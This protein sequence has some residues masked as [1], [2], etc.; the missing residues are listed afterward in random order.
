MS[1]L[2]TPTACQLGLPVGGLDA[3]QHRL[4]DHELA[5]LQVAC[6]GYVKYAE[7]RISTDGRVHLTVQLLQPH[8]GA[9]I[10]TIFHGEPGRVGEFEALRDRLLVPRTCAMLRG[11]R[12]DPHQKWRGND[13]VLLVRCSGVHTLGFMPER[14]GAELPRQEKE[15]ANA[16]R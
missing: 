13:V 10:V 7:V 8:D 5:E 1:A 2:A 12:L 14:R 11:E 15:A 9:P 3:P 4:S 16:C 6:S